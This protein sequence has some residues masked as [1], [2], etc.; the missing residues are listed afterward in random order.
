MV[1]FSFIRKD[2]AKRTVYIDGEVIA[3]S[4]LRIGV[5][6]ANLDP[7]STARDTLLKDPQGRPVIPGSSWKGIFRSTGERILRDKGLEVCS[8][9]GGDNCL[10]KRDL[11]DEFQKL[12]KNNVNGAL[13]MFWK[14]TCLNCKTFGA[15]SVIGAV[16]LADS[17][18]SHYTL[19]V[20][21]IIAISRTEGAV[22]EGALASVEFVEPGSKFSFRLIGNNLPNYVIG[23]LV[24]IMEQ[25]HLGLSQVGGQKS[26]GFGF[27][28]FGKMKFTSV[29]SEKVGDEDK[30]IKVTVAEGE[31]SKFFEQ[32]KPFKEAFD[33]VKT[34]Y[35]EK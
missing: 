35:P 29:G 15:M 14:K 20:R 19:G 11:S 32:M 23:Y 6:R 5:G 34:S 33:S 26:R 10:E 25:I 8:G 18:A 3:M 16:K 4:P 9:I 24:R 7:T 1:D 2:I 30:E 28:Q 17:V 27:V 31:G 22:A 21:T 13:D 12:I